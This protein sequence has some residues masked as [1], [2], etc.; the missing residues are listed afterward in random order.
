MIP[1]QFDHAGTFSQGVARAAVGNR[2]GYI[3]RSGKFV[4]N[5]QFDLAGDFEEGLAAVWL[6]DRQGYIN[7]AGR[8][9]WNP[10]S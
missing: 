7:K 2:F 5:P 3:D 10:T 6:G 9:V 1:P 4:I 8:Y